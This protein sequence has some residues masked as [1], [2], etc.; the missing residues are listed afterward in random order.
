MLAVI[1]RHRLVYAIRKVRM[2]LVDLPAAV[3]FSKRELVGSVSIDFVGGEKDEHSLRTELPGC[4]QEDECPVGVDGKI[5]AGI[6]SRP[7]M[8]RLGSGMNDKPNVGGVCREDPG[9]RIAISD[10]CMDVRKA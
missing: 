9:D 7:V 2:G 1:D 8:G 10:V 4:F 3:E 6:L 5:G